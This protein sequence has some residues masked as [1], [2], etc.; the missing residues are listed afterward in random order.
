VNT[1]L[2][3]FEPGPAA[4]FALF[5]MRMGGIVMIAPIYSARTVPVAVRTGIVVI[6]TAAMAPALVGQST[7]ALTPATFASELLVGFA[8]GFA[9]SLMVGAAEV[10]GD[11]LALQG[12]LS[13][14][15]TLDPLTGV[16]SQALGDFMKMVVVTLLLAAGGHILMLEALGDSIVAVPP[17]RPIA[18]SDSLL[19]M[20]MLGG[21]L[22]TVGIQIAAP[23]MAA[24]FVGN[25]AM[26]VLA[27]TAPQIQVFML[28]YPLQIVISITVLMLSLPLLGVTMNGWSEHYRTTVVGLFEVMGG[29]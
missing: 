13:G 29:R 4:A 10:A 14:A 24:V 28:A 20:A 23:V 19:T 8:I 17:G 18:A 22:F 5:A 27:R 2:N 16:Q 1:L 11:V 6:C 9:A 15:G 12:G 26:G 7:V 25:L 3:P 21:T